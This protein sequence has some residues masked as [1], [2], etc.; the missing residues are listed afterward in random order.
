MEGDY[1]ADPTLFD[2]CVYGGSD[3]L[4]MANWEQMMSVAPVDN[5]NLWDPPRHITNTYTPSC[6]LPGDPEADGECG[7]EYKMRVETFGLDEDGLGLT[8]PTGA[9]VD[10]TPTEDGSYTGT[11]F[12]NAWYI[13]DIHPGKSWA[14]PDTEREPN[15]IHHVSHVRWVRLACV[16]PVQASLIEVSPR[17]VEFPL[18]VET[19]TVGTFEVTVIN[20]GNVLLNVSPI[21]TFED[22]GGPTG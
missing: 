18:W 22:A 13:D 19:G 11:H 21:E 2:D 5:A 1:D 17:N 12:L 16:E 6:G 7:N 10:L 9:L 3:R 15:G 8:W 4:Y 20:D 14:W